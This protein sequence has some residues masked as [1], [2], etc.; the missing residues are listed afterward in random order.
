M[1]TEKERTEMLGLMLPHTIKIQ[2]FTKIK[3][4]NEDE[5]P[6]GVLAVVR[7]FD[8]FGDPVKAVGH[9]YF[10][11]WTYVE[12]S[13]DRKGQRLAFWDRNLRTPEE[14]RLY[15]TRAEM[16]EFQLAWTGGVGA[17]QPGRKLLLSATYRAP[18]DE[19]F[20]DEYV[21]DFQLSPGSLVPSTT[22][23]E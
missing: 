18:W 10:E 4:F 19:T 5:V 20:Q 3:S 11:L 6:D 13:G 23:P 17:V 7:A 22:R 15:W 12:A 1:P 8:V 14:V 2:P 21:L 9:W 16:F